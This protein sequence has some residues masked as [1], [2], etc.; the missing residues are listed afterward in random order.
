MHDVHLLFII[1]KHFAVL[2][3]RAICAIRMVFFV[4]P[5]KE[6]NTYLKFSL[7]LLDEKRKSTRTDKLRTSCR[8]CLVLSLSEVELYFYL[9]NFNL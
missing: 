5:R 4:I 3:T 2:I 8:I 9:N 7:G 1:C 6:V